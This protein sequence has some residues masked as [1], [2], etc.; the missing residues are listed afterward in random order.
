MSAARPPHELDVELG[1]DRDREL[2][3][4]PGQ[5][6]DQAQAQDQEKEKEKEKDRGD[7]H[8]DQARGQDQDPE[9]WL[10]GAVPHPLAAFARARPVHLALRVR[11]PDGVVGR[12][13]DA[14]QLRD[15]VAALATQLRDAG[16]QA[17]HRVAL[18][19]RRSAAWVIALHAIGWLG[20]SVV[21]LDPNA[22][23]E[24]LRARTSAAKQTLVIDVER[25][26]PRL[27]DVLRADTT[28]HLRGEAIEG[29]TLAPAQRPRAAQPR[30]WGLADERALLFTS[31]STGDP[32]P[33]PLT[34]AQLLFATVGGALHL[35]HDLADCWHACLPPWHIG[36]LAIVLRTAWCQTTLDLG[37]GFFPAAMSRAIDRGTITQLS[38]VPAMLRRLTQARQG[39]RF[40]ASLRW[41]L[42]GGAAAD[43]ADI[44]AAEALGAVVC[45]TWGMTESA[46]QIATR[47]PATPRDQENGLVGPPLP[48]AAVEQDPA[49]ARLRISGPQLGAAAP[50]LTQDRGEVSPQG[51][52]RIFGRADRLVIS[53]GRNI[54]PAAVERILLRHPAVAQALVFGVPHPGLGEQLVAAIA[55]AEEPDAAPG[56]GLAAFAAGLLH[57]YDRPRRWAL[58]RSI[59]TTAAGKVSAASRGSIRDRVVAALDLEREPQGPQLLDEDRRRIARTEARQVDKRVL[60]LDPGVKN[61]I[62]AADREDDP[63]PPTAVPADEDDPVDRELQAIPEPH[64]PAKVSLDVD[65]RQAPTSGLHRRKPRPE[66]AGEDILP[67]LVAPLEEA[68]KEG[69]TGGVDLGKADDVEVGIEHPRDLGPR[70]EAKQGPR[71]TRV[72]AD[73]DAALAPA[74]PTTARTTPTTATK[75]LA[76]PDVTEGSTDE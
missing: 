37:L 55:P 10:G 29:W 17:G 2:D 49:S 60:M 33:V 64:R 38:L 75:T 8:L 14:T 63:K 4:D 50:Y 71:P 21:P 44:V 45:P 23:P 72:Q 5:D 56:D 1:H 3:P 59:P 39:K 74:G 61:I 32:K 28:L 47:S 20:A 66:G 36:G 31:G 19:G 27:D 18:L 73:D 34:T 15:A 42:L 13:L 57:R 30:P 11:G 7:Q 35:G 9:A 65:H 67:G 6:Q 22:P 62:G 40:P 43:E 48:F 68:A 16:V 51:Q 76:K 46:A 52:V 26:D 25:L 58:L 53:G 41:I 70:T 69:D 24:T 54:D 12:P